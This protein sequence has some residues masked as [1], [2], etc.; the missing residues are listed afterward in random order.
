M[1]N[2]ATMKNII[3]CC[4]LLL[5]CS[6]LTSIRLKYNL[7]WLKAFQNTFFFRNVFHIIFFDFTTCLITQCKKKQTKPVIAKEVPLY[8]LNLAASNN[9]VKQNV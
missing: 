5:L 7:N 8:S 1:V 2:Y 3:A 9:S 6:E 4:Y